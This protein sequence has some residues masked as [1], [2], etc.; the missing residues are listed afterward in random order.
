MLRICT[1]IERRRARGQAVRR[2]A[3][4]FALRWRSKTY[5]KAPHIAVRLSA[6]RIVSLFYLWKRAGRRPEAFALRYKHKAAISPELARQFLRGCAAPGALS[7]SAA[8][9][10]FQPA[11]FSTRALIDSLAPKTRRQIRALHVSRRG[12]IAQDRAIGRR[13]RALRL[14]L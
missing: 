11:G 7:M 14:A 13:I 2:A 9:R 12:L 6:A 8:I 4:Y 1:G 5:R 10:Q 3:R